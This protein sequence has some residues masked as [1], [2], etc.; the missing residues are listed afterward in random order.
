MMTIRLRK[1]NKTQYI[2]SENEIDW[3]VLPM[4]N[5]PF[6]VDVNSEYQE[7]DRGDFE[8]LHDE[9]RKFAWN[10]LLDHLAR[11]ERSRKESLDHLRKLPLHPDL[12]KELVERAISKKFISDSRFAE[13]YAGSL[14]RMQKSREEIRHKLKERGIDELLIEKTLMEFVTQQQEEDAIEQRIEKLLIR[15]R[16]LKPRQQYEKILTS[17]CRNG[18]SYEDVK[19]KVRLKVYGDSNF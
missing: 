8:I 19:E 14:L 17:L 11:Q 4:A 13:L 10:R 2:I 1:K 3:G 12:C 9:I 16:D 15:Y 18:F 6:F 7:I 5:L